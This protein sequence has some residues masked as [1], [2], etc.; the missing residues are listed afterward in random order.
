MPSEAAPTPRDFWPRHLEAALRPDQ[1]VEAF[2]L[3]ALQAGVRPTG[4][5][6]LRRGGDSP[7]S[8]VRWPPPS[9]GGGGEIWPRYGWWSRFLNSHGITRWVDL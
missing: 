4:T 7:L 8:A 3:Y 2:F 1:P 6:A 5:T 9:D